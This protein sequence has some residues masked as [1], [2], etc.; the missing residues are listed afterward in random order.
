MSN[1]GRNVLIIVVIS[2]TIV[3][4]ATRDKKI[5]LFSKKEPSPTSP[6][7]TSDASSVSDKENAKTAADA[8]KLAI[9]SGADENDLKDLKS[10]VF[11][12]YGL[13]MSMDGS[14][15]QVKNQSGTL[16]LSEPVA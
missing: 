15:I 6:P 10:S 3:F 4:F 14:N 8:L 11:D 16:L 7:S 1:A 13:S 5:S 2:G 12:Q 9:S